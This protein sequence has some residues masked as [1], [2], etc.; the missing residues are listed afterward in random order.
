MRTAR[1]LVTCSSTRGLRAVGHGGIDFQAANHRAGM[2]H[3]RIGL[4]ER[5]RSGVS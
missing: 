4:R 5:R 2:Q 3:Q 1:P